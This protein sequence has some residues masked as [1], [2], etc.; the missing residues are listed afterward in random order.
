M[1]PDLVT[2]SGLSAGGA[3]AT[4][5]H[6]ALSGTVKGAAT[7]AGGKLLAKLIIYQMKFDTIT[8]LLVS[9]TLNNTW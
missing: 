4:Q 5:I 3:F 8:N 7:F 9:E 1:D 2:V 6:V